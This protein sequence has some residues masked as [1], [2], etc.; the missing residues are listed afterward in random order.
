MAQ[1]HRILQG[2]HLRQCH[3][4]K[5]IWTFDVNAVINWWAAFLGMIFETPL[6]VFLA[7]GRTE[8]FAAFCTGGLKWQY[9]TFQ[10]LDLEQW[11]YLCP[12]CPY[13]TRDLP[14][15]RWSDQG[16]T[17]QVAQGRKILKGKY[18]SKSQSQSF[19]CQ[20]N[21]FRQCSNQPLGILFVGDLWS[22]ISDPPCS[23]M[24]RSSRSP[25]NKYIKNMTMTIEDFLKLW[26]YLFYLCPSYPYTIHDHL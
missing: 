12:S 16:R 21:L 18:S 17:L 8:V 3:N 1:D 15:C 13:T 26:S 10:D 14:W 6:L 22:T 20:L 2:E 25:L 19:S 9:I 11:T 23:Q 4:Q 7:V 5:N 24:D